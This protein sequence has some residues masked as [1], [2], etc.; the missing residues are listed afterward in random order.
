MECAVCAVYVVYTVGS[1]ACVRTVSSVRTVPSHGA[2][3]WQSA[4]TW[5]VSDRTVDESS[6]LEL[7]MISIDKAST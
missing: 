2:P 7:F 3:S 5:L 4:Y 1:E 6:G